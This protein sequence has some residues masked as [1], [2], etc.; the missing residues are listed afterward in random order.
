MGRLWPFFTGE[1]A[2]ATRRG[3]PNGLSKHSLKDGLML[4][5]LNWEVRPTGAVL[6]EG[7]CAAQSSAAPG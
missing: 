3:G 6:P 4:D 2:C 1:G 5:F 7:V